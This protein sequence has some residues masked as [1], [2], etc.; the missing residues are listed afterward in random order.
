MAVLEVTEVDTTVFFVHFTIA[1]GT[2][3]VLNKASITSSSY[4]S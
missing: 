4:P 2:D 3:F 1:M